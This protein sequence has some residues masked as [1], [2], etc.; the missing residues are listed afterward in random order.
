VSTT[1]TVFNHDRN[2][3][4]LTYVYPVVS[5]R[6]RGVSI[7]VNLNPDNTCNFRCVYCQVPD[8]VFGNGPNIDLPQLETELRSQLEDVL[9]GDFMLT[10]VPEG[11]RR[12]NDVAFSG[13]GEPTTSPDF[14]AA[15]DVVL[16][17]MGELGI[18]GSTKIVLITNG[19]RTDRAD[20]EP[21]LRRLGA[22]SA[23][24]WFKLD[25][26]TEQ[27]AQRINSSNAPLSARIERLERVATICPTWIQSCFF[28]ID[29]APPPATEIDAYVAL[30]GSFV[31]RRVPLA[32]V[33]LYGIARQSYQPEAPRLSALDATWFDAL[34]ARI[35][36][37]G[38]SVSVSV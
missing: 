34:A 2:S 5:R 11:S 16:R 15:V 6:A 33:L 8:L 28:A 35:A 22:N 17:V 14:G 27:G 30:L 21:A 26:A 23:E 9:H 19:S 13:N 31:A 10:R 1:L 12:L 4:E 18:L 20:V 25:A 24:I 36:E 32:G 7:G 3:A 37:L 38:L 29:G